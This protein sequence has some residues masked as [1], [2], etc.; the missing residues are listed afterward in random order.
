MRAE[1]VNFL[2]VYVG[3]SVGQDVA[4]K[5]A[6]L[7]SLPTLPSGRIGVLADRMHISLKPASRSSFT[8]GGGV[9]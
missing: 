2:N 6:S 3:I 1:T 9:G 8:G 5:G 4:I 7:A